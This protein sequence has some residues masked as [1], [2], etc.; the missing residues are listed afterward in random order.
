MIA[1]GFLGTYMGV[2]W[3]KRMTNQHFDQ[4]FKWVITLLALRLLWSAF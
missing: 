4:L 3:L 1:A 2:R